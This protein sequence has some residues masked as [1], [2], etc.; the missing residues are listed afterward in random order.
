[1]FGSEKNS[2]A[3][4]TQLQD[5]AL[6]TPENQ[7]TCSICWGFQEYD[8][9]IRQKYEDKQID[10]KNH[11]NSYLKAKRFLVTYIDGNR[12]KKA[13]VKEC[14]RCGKKIAETSLKIKK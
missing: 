14:P 5:Q 3:M 8:H 10:V 7:E 2:P 9:K 6:S 4:E 12:Y 13:E 1:M 11:K